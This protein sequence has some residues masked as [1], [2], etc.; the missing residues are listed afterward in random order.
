MNFSINFNKKILASF[1]AGGL[2]VSSAIYLQPTKAQSVT[3]LSGQYGCILN[4]NFS[5]IP[6]TGGVNSN[7]TGSNFMMYLDFNGRNAQM[8]VVGLNSWG[9]SAYSNATATI[10]A[11]VLSV[12]AGPLTNSFT[13]TINFT[14]QG[15]S[16]NITTYNLMSVNG[17]NT[18]LVQGGITGNNDGEPTTGVCNKV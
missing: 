9:N 8:T 3:T 5:G 7:I 1:V 14:Y 6:I 2:L 17:G 13:A 18:L 10:T 11:G 16:G 4:R 12:S 15:Q